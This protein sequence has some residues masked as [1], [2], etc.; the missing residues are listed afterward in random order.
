MTYYYYTGSSPLNEQ[1]PGGG[2]QG[3]VATVVVGVLVLM[4]LAVVAVVGV[5]LLIYVLCKRYRRK[6][7][8][9]MH[10]DIL[11]M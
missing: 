4:V 3:D 10:L 11:A 5:V 8:Q 7:L 6:L 2:D 1:S 9:R